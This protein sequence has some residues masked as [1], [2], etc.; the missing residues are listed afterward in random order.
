MPLSQAD[1]EIVAHLLIV[2]EVFLN[3]VSTIAKAKHKLTKAVVGISFHNV[4]EY[5]PSTNRD[6]GLGAE[7]GFFV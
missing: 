2:Q 1:G 6:E 4:P 7:L 5:R 3:H